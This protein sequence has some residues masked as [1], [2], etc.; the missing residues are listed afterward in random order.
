MTEPHTLT[1]NTTPHPAHTTTN[2]NTHAQQQPY[3]R[4]QQQHTHMHNNN[5]TQQMQLFQKNIE[6]ETYFAIFYFVFRLFL[7]FSV[8]LIFGEEGLGISLES[9]KNR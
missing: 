2:N 7:V 9:S 1:H 4:A 8:F 6:K 3:T 5:A